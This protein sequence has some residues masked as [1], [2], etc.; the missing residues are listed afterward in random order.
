MIYLDSQSA[1]LEGTLAASITS[2]QLQCTVA[3]RTENMNGSIGNGA[4]YRSTSNHITDFTMLPA[5][6]DPNTVRAIEYI[7]VYNPDSVTA[8]AIVKIDVGGSETILK[9]Q[10][11]SPTQ[12]LQY[13]DHDGWSML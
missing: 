8:Q 11:I 4:V 6:P 2:N 3:Y 1:V 7:G 5:P 12:T 10:L 9:R 13:I